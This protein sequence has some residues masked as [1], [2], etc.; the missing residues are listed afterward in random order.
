MTSLLLPRSTPSAQAV[1][2]GCL[3][4][5]LD[6]LAERSVE[7]HSLMVVRHGHVIAEGW[8]S[9]FSADR[10]H[11]LYSLTKSFTSIAVGFAVQDGLLALDDRVVDLLPDH[12]PPDAGAWARQLTVHHLLS[13]ATGH[14][15]DTLPEAWSLHPG[16]LVKGFLRVPPQD[17]PGTRHAYNNSTSFV[18]ARI[19]ERVTGRPIEELLDERLFG[20]MGVRPVEW[21]RVGSGATFGFQGLHLTTEAVAAFGELLLRDGRWHGKQLVTAEWVRLATAHHIETLQSD[22][23]LRT[24]DWLEGYGYQFWRSRHG[25][26]GDGA[27]G[28]FC[29]V[30]P[31]ADLVVAMTAATAVMQEALD[32]VWECLLPGLDTVAARDDAVVAKRLQGLSLPLVPGELAPGRAAEATVAASAVDSPL[33][34]GTS[35][36]VRPVADGW[37][38]TFDTGE[39]LFEVEAGHGR[40]RESAPLGRPIVAAGAWQDS[41]FVADLYV[42][43]GP[44]RVRL[45]VDSGTATATWNAVPLVG[46]EMLRLLR[47]PL[48][49]RPE[50]S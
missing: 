15:A 40:W 44:H 13:M 49:T 25:Y 1:D 47:A 20:P 28:Q 21:D 16:D 45:V 43:T 46:P 7:C 29:L 14:R 32:A 10:P 26:R 11:L 19:V 37:R 24:A 38:L 3:V 39:T 18:L 5:L 42:I 8:W 2:P 4:A 35:V 50:A 27:L 33:P 31:E 34:Q 23:G 30:V 12:V 6:R 36:A 22:D 48:M 41:V 9:P 17:P